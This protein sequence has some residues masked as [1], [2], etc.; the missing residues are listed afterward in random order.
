MT[1]PLDLPSQALLHSRILRR[2]EGTVECA[3]KPCSPASLKFHGG[4]F[5]FR[6]IK[7]ADRA[8]FHSQTGEVWTGRHIQI[9]IDLTQ[10]TFEFGF[11]VLLVS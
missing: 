10:A 1:K 8:A 3:A 2:V 5:V 9:Q 11:E 4:Q 7:V 6:V